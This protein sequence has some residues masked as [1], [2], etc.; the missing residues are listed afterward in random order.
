MIRINLLPAAKRKAERRPLPRLTAPLVAAAFVAAAAGLAGGFWAEGRSLSGR[1]RV[2]ERDLL[3]ARTAAAAARKIEEEIAVLRAHEAAV[4]AVERAKA[5]RWSGR[6]DRVAGLLDG[7]AP[8]VW[9]TSVR[10]SGPGAGG[11][12]AAMELGC[13]ATRDPARRR[14]MGHA[15]AGFVEALREEFLGKEGGFTGYDDRYAEAARE[16]PGTAEGWSEAFTVRL[17]RVPSGKPD[18]KEP[19]D[20]R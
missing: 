5:E 14:E 15:A 17:F 4:T 18:R 13:E 7:R 16:R 1:V 8:K 9:L 3:H 11:E 20:G 12:G 19:G 2:L 6:L 10:C